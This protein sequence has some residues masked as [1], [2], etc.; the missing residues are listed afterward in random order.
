MELHIGVDDVDSPDG[1]CTSYL[2]Y[3]LTLELQ[4][5]GARFLD[6][7]Y[8]VRLNPN[9]PFKTRGNAAISIHVD[10]GEEEVSE[11]VEL[12]ENLVVEYSEHH[13]KT[14]P[15]FAVTKGRVSSV[16]RELYSTAL[17]SIVPRGYVEEMVKEGGAEIII[18]GG[19]KNKRGIIGAL[20]AIG[21]YPLED[22]TYELLVYRNPTLRGPKTGLSED[23]ILDIDRRYRPIIFA[24]YDYSEKRL[25]AAP[26]GSDP[27]LLGLR[28]ISARVLIE[29][30]DKYLS[31]HAKEI[32]AEGFIL[33]KSNQ[34][35]NAHLMRKKRIADIRPYDSVVVNG[36]I[37]GV[38]VIM[39]GGH[40]KVRV[41]D[42]SGCIDSMFYK[43]TG[44]LNR[45]A[46]LLRVG[47]EVEIGGGVVPRKGLTL[48]VEFLRVLSLKTTVNTLNPLCPVCGARM[49]S[50]GRN[51]GFKCPKCGY[52][53]SRLQK[54][55]EELPRILE[56]GLYIQSVRAYRHLTRPLEIQGLSPE[57]KLEPSPI[58]GTFL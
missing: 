58:A 41:C 29:V 17:T 35:T 51:K 11:V 14:S 45:A 54:I 57:P 38:P 6:L 31:P 30:L 53:S 21:A 24:T 12:V 34:A 22:Y 42:R 4:R 55:Q 3:L 32:G 7:P 10:V 39:E 36:V 15:G 49:E 2:G 8:L 37:E 20:A 16:L 19:R 9:I 46:R 18:A 50:A 27:V 13:G 52:H 48:N 23:V 25:L 43:E 1:Y 26:R 33:Y 5:M 56:P 28:S 44:R 47:D 40:V